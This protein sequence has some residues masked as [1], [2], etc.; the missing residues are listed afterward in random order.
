MDLRNSITT[1]GNSLILS[2]NTNP[3]LT[4]DASVPSEPPSGLSSSSSPSFPSSSAPP[5]L[6]YVFGTPYPPT[7]PDLPPLESSIRCYT[8]RS[9]ES[10]L[11][12]Y[13]YTTDAGWGCMVRCTQMMISRVLQQSSSSSS[14]SSPSSPA[15]AAA[16]LV[17][18]SGVAGLDLSTPFM[19]GGTYGLKRLLLIGARHDKYPGEWYGPS[20]ACR[21]L[22]DVLEGVCGVKVEDSGVVYESE[23]L[24]LACG[25]E[26]VREARDDEDPLINCGGEAEGREWKTPVLLL[27]PARL[28]VERMSGKGRKDLLEYFECRFS[29]GCLGG[30]PRH[31]I[32]FY[33]K[34]G[35]DLVGKDP[36]WVQQESGT[37]ERYDAT[38]RRES[39]RCGVDGVDPSL[40]FSFY[41]RDGEEWK[42]L[43][44]WLRGWG[45]LHLE[46][47]R[48]DLGDWDGGG[49]GEGSYEDE[50]EEDWEF[51]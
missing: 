46:W 37:R 3:T 22:R 18:G 43:K 16:G 26:E 12:P 4:S 9:W 23:V 39:V 19:H 27:V 20:T 11:L 38:C 28:G 35:C 21:V 42:D 13:P 29:A 17:E 24:D 30:T 48:P 5:I 50:E 1:L 33:G 34:E 40:A 2:S 15:P 45:G 41:C 10:P 7:S 25:P 36:H 51:V 32:Y 14:S 31:A 47:A 6:R 49:E 44:E 8:Y